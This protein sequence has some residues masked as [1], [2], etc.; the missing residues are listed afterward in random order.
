M[1]DRRET[2]DT[3]A[4]DYTS[5]LSALEGRWWKRALDVQAPYRWNL[6]RLGLGFTLDL[7]CGLGRNLANLGGSGV[8]VDHN[9]SSVAT[10]RERGLEAYTPE[11]FR[12]ST[13]A[14]PGRFDSLLLAHVAEHL[15]AEECTALV[16]DY[17]GYV[18]PGGALVVI[19][20]QERGYATDASH[21]RFVQPP[22]MGE[23]VRAVGGRVERELSFP[24]PR[25]V[26]KVFPYNE[27]VVVGRLPG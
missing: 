15:A 16:Q 23:L 14:V 24:F 20:P 11:E 2:T 6:R 18:R 17:A 3:R 5:R 21:V 19:C 9:A 7:G 25:L 26:G 8:G 10:A 13:H 12:Q 1:G 27:F 4:A 22:Q